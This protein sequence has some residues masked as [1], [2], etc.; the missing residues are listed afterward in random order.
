LVEPL[1][2]NVECSRGVAEMALAILDEFRAAF[3]DELQPH[4]P[5]ARR[6]GEYGEGYRTLSDMDVAVASRRRRR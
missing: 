3:E 5:P 1:K 4:H 6:H 2:G